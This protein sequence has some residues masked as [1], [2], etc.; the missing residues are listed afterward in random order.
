MDEKKAIMKRVL[1]ALKNSLGKEIPQPMLERAIQDTHYKFEGFNLEKL[2]KHLMN[3][4]VDIRNKDNVIKRAS[5]Y[6]FYDLKDQYTNI[7]DKWMS[8]ADEKIEEIKKRITSK[9]PVISFF[10]RRF[11]GIRHGENSLEG[12]DIMRRAYF[13]MEFEEAETKIW[14]RLGYFAGVALDA[15]SIPIVMTKNIFGK[16]NIRYNL[17][18]EEISGMAASL[19]GKISEMFRT[20]S[21]LGTAALA[22]KI[23]GSGALFSSLKGVTAVLTSTV[24]LK[25]AAAAGGPAAAG[26]GVYFALTHFGVGAPGAIAV[27]AIISLIG[28]LIVFYILSRKYEKSY[29][30]VKEAGK[31][32][33]APLGLAGSLI[34]PFGLVA[35]INYYGISSFGLTHRM[36]NVLT[37]TAMVVGGIASYKYINSYNDVQSEKEIAKQSLFKRFK[38]RFDGLK[39]KYLPKNQKE[40]LKY[41]GVAAFFLAVAFIFRYFSKESKEEQQ[42]RL[43]YSLDEYE[44]ELV[45][46]NKLSNLTNNNNN[47]S[48]EL[49]EID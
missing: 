13:E 48:S 14:R 22:L 41:L 30:E 28:Y 9:N 42:L 33:V 35:S 36:V 39:K 7:Y 4:G 37:L 26:I 8:G 16:R 46:Q 5:E 34:I 43:L 49:D 40:R 11:Y 31:S 10:K 17:A 21:I 20:V 47:D 44:S 32:L 38:V 6:I 19:D 24:A 15:V 27:G 29:L 45:L 3:N 25:L 1:K 18:S 12:W 23:V 2:V